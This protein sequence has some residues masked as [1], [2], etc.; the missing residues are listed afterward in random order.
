MFKKYFSKSQSEP[1]TGMISEGTGNAALEAISK[2]ISNNN[3]VP[4]EKNTQDIDLQVA[5]ST[6]ISLGEVADELTEEQKY[7]ALKRYDLNHLENMEDL[8]LV[9]LFMLEQLQA[10]SVSEAIEILKEALPVHEH[11]INF[12][13]GLWE[14]YCKIIAKCEQGTLTNFDLALKKESGDKELGIKE[15]AKEIHD[16]EVNDGDSE[17]LEHW[18][19]DA[20]IE[21]SL[22]AFWSP[23]PEIRAISD[24]FDDPNELCETFRA[25]VISI[26]WQGI[27]AFINTY[28]NARQP[29]VSLSGVVVQVFI[30]PC[31]LLWAKIVPAWTIRFY[32]DYKIELNPGPWT[33]KEQMFATLIF[34]VEGGANFVY[35]ALMIQSSKYFYYQ[36]WAGWGYGILLGLSLTCMGLGLAG[37]LRCF[38]VYPYEQIWPLIIP[39][40]AVN[41]ALMSIEKK[42]NLFGWKISRYRFFFYCFI[43][44]FIYFWVPDYLFQ[45]LSQFS[46]MTWISKD[47]VNLDNIVGFNGGIGLNPITTFDFNIMWNMSLPLVSPAYNT[48][49]NYIGVVITAFTSLG[50]YYS[51]YKWTGY[52]PLI[53]N[54][55]YDNQGNAYDT[56]R[57]L[58]DK[59]LDEQALKDYSLPFYG[60]WN[61]VA[62]GAGYA[63]VPFLFLYMILEFWKPFT[64]SFKVLCKSLKRNGTSMS[65]YKD[66]FCRMNSV[67]PEAPEWWFLIVFFSAL[68]CGI[69]SIRGYETDTPVWALFFAL[70]FS[71]VVMIP[72]IQFLAVTGSLITLIGVVEIVIGYALRGHIIAYILMKLFGSYIPEQC[73]NYLSNQ[74]IAHYAKVPPRA[75]F[76]G[77][78]LTSIINVFITIGL[79]RWQ[80]GM[81]NF[82]NPDLALAPN[83]MTCPSTRSYFNDAVVF[84]LVGPKTV[85]ALLYP[86]LKYCFLIGFL[87]VFPCI[88]F[89]WYAPRKWTTLFQPVLWLGGI[90]AAA[91]YNLSYYTPGLYWAIGFMWYLKNRYTAWW[92]KYNYL[93]YG[94]VQAGVA[95]SSVIIFFSVFYHDKSI[96]WWG[97]NVIYEGVDG[98]MGAP[99]LNATLHAEGGYFGP[100]KGEWS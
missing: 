28:F 84:G 30:Y 65:N 87:L 71:L 94:G 7:R 62:T 36:S 61:L 21:A 6:Q 50:L 37:L 52:I 57:V 32:K 48:I 64:R 42:E 51:N 35:Q 99:R 38:F 89:K 13:T 33:A 19:F 17:D 2:T 22:I 98:A 44:S 40:K 75:M 79:I 91:P 85:F 90:S 29:S 16:Y 59:G 23:Y 25:Y 27:G 4:L 72:T 66:P 26:I 82:C 80:T 67:Y 43:A 9:A 78:L 76:R 93:F 54:G 86:I 5:R 96:S 45:A 3:G 95:F 41:Q 12:P 60:A 47:N 63:T 88:A 31:G 73:Q 18:E 68:A 39:T 10:L 49:Q 56:S 77:Q 97:N 58:T 53:S 1:R 8:P 83:R 81:E 100:R 11:D 14:R 70:F 20:R 46:W 74:K 55:L 92:I 24:P 15:S 34:I 69:A